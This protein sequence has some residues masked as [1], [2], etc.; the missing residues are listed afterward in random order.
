[1]ETDPQL[2]FFAP[3]R[4]ELRAMDVRQKIA[5]ALQQAQ[6]RQDTFATEIWNAALSAF[7][8]PIPQYDLEEQRRQLLHNLDRSGR[9]SA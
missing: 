7:S 4:L 3:G 6:E 9:H 5:G 1:L 2:W 8:M